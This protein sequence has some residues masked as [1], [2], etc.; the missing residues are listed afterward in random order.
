MGTSAVSPMLVGLTGNI[1][2][3]KTFI[4]N[5][6]YQKFGVQVI[7]T[8]AI[9]S[10]HMKNRIDDMRSIDHRFVEYH[11]LNINVILEI[12]FSDPEKRYAVE[13]LIHPL[14]MN[15][16]VSMPKD[17]KV[18]YCFVETALA[19]RPD[20]Q[21]HFDAIVS[22]LAD[23]WVR[24]FRIH[25]RNVNLSPKQVVSIM[26]NQMSDSE[27]RALSSYSIENNLNAKGFDA[28]Q[29]SYEMMK[30]IA[31]VHESL[32]LLAKIKGEKSCTAI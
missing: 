13:Q 12:I 27:M 6:F 2:S 19:F 15:E 14:V 20:V 17:N 11:G 18:P 28:N 32:V 26:D 31:F 21:C 8:D 24:M 30:D 9:A 5:L 3:G 4:G 16:V 25:E 22:V 10:W 29:Q 1:G 23:Q 7:N